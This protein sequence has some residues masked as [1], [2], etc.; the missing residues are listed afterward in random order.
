[1]GPKE[2]RD[3]A[4]GLGEKPFRGDQLAAWLYR[5]GA[6]SFSE[7]TDISLSARALFSENAE[8]GPI[9]TISRRE[10]SQDGAVKFLNLLPDGEMVESVL[11]RERDRVTLCVSSQVGCALGCAFCR[12]GTMGLRRDLTQGEIIGQ[13]LAARK[14]IPDPIGNLVFMGMGEPLLNRPWLHKALSVILDPRYLAVPHK[15]LTVSTVGP[16]PGLKAFGAAFPTVP[17]AISLNAADQSLRES[18]MPVA[19]KYPLKDLK[20]ALL[21]YPLPPKRRLTIAWV[22]LDGVNDSLADA[23]ALSRFLGGLRA[24]VNLIPFNPWPGAPFGR[25]SEKRVLEFQELLLGKKITTIVRKSRGS[26]VGGAC[27]Q[28]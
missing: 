6:V 19:R 3:F 18:L 7:M 1:M 14:E 26:Q 13:I 25:P 8:L 2:L 12:T 10:P 24:K 17:L 20:E 21:A 28:L 4:A 27:G 5:K 15:G 9:V 22:L 11:I 16:I 23:R